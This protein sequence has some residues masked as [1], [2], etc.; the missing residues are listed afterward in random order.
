MSWSCAFGASPLNFRMEEAPPT[1]AARV[2]ACTRLTSCVRRSTAHGAARP[3]TLLL[4][5]TVCGPMTQASRVRSGC[6]DRWVQEA[7]GW[8][9]EG[10]ADAARETA[11]TAVTAPAQE[12][13]RKRERP[14]GL[15]SEMAADHWVQDAQ[16]VQEQTETRPVHRLLWILDH[17]PLRGESEWVD[18]PAPDADERRA[19]W[20]NA[21]R[22]EAQTGAG[23]GG[24]TQDGRDAWRIA[25]AQT[26][27]C[28]GCDGLVDLLAATRR[29]RADRRGRFRSGDGCGSRKCSKNHKAGQ[30]NHGQAGQAHALRMGER[31]LVGRP[32]GPGPSRVLLLSTSDMISVATGVQRSLGG[33]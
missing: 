16:W 19:G 32:E 28:P 15:A 20:G 7:D 10:A 5:S 22:P 8:V 29:A 27:V 33:T 31:L 18:V 30:Y 3:A 24:N 4:T 1:S 23:S 13:A 2:A 9:Q 11:A 14:P 17:D 6:D 12:P 26:F 25:R 21:W